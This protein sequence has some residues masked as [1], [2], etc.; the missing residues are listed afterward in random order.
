VIVVEQLRK[1]I[2]MTE[3]KASLILKNGSI[4]PVDGKNSWAQAVAIADDR[5]VLVGSNTDVETYIGPETVEIDLD[6]KMV[7]PAFVDSHMH[8]AHSAYIYKYHLNLFKVTGDDLILTYLNTI[9][10]FVKMNSDKPWII[11]GGYLRSAFDEIGPR[12]EW[13]DEIES[14]RPIAITSKDG[15]S[16]WVNSKAL[17]IAKIT[18][19]TP[20]PDEGVIKKDPKT[21]EPSGLLQEPGAMN[22]VGVHIPEPQ[23]EQIKES[24]LWLQSWLNAKG[25]TTTH[26]AMLGIDER[27]IIEAYDELAREGMLTVRYRASWNISPDGDV[28]DQIEKGKALA[29]KFTH[30]NFK[31][32]S[33]KF[34]ADHVIEEET[35]YLIEP[36]AHRDDNWY[37]IKVWSD[38]ALR[39]AFAQVDSARYQIHVH[40]IGDAAAEYTLDA[41]EWLIEVN[42]RRDSRHSFA[43]LQLARPEDVQRISDL[44]VSVHTSPY[45]M[46]IDDYHWELNLPYLGHERAF[47]QQY[48]LNS[49]FEAGANVTIASDFYVSEP[50]VMSAFYCG[51]RRQVPKAEFDQSHGSDSTYRWVSETDSDLEYG[52]IGVLPPLGERASLEKLIQASTINGAF[53]NFLDAEL[54]SIEVG[55]LADLVILEHNIFD[56]DLEQ[57]PTTRVAMTFFEGKEVFRNSEIF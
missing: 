41:L 13:L 48:P 37:G 31:A 3:K 49:L 28:L 21:G 1:D 24:L 5:I 17:E 25:I 12:K 57:I 33:F 50:N 39:V 51:M 47:N 11:G 30:S 45:W 53:A 27:T 56:I 35:G 23:K 19:D 29:K 55:K 43:H 22:L 52:D 46:T 20:Q 18:K 8:P 6:G 34:F 42:G 26:E 40:V 14:E 36:Y 7:L 54:G 10:E 16:M 4:Y 2:D 15:H 38:D 44:G 9:R 32:H